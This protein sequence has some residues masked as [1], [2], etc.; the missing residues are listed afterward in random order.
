MSRADCLAVVD[1]LHEVD[2]IQLGIVSYIEGLLDYLGQSRLEDNKQPRHLHACVVGRVD[3]FV[4]MPLF[5]QATG[6]L[7]G[8]NG[9]QSVI[10]PD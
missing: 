6:I 8:P 4:P 9:S 10:V 2:F 5:S 7:P 1:E 3:V